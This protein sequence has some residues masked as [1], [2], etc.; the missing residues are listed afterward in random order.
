MDLLGLVFEKF[1]VI[2]FFNILDLE[3]SVIGFEFFFIFGFCLVY[4]YVLVFFLGFRG[5][6]K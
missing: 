2:V 6:F 5:G 1:G 4:V 3:F